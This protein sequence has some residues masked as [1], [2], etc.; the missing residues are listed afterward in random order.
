MSAARLRFYAMYATSTAVGFILWGTMVLVGGGRVHGAREL[1]RYTARH[2]AIDAARKR[3]PYLAPV[4][5]LA[6]LLVTVALVVVLVRG[7]L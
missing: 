7:A 6:C 2:H 1:I 3:G 4:T 5:L